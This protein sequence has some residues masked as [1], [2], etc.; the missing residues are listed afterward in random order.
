MKSETEINTQWKIIHDIYTN[1]NKTFDWDDMKLGIEG[2]IYL[3]ILQ[4]NPHFFDDF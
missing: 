2:L 1:K 3:K 4:V